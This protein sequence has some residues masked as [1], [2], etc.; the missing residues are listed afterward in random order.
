MQLKKY[1]VTT[2]CKPL[3]TPSCPHTAR[4]SPPP[5]GNRYPKFGD[6]HSHE[7][8]CIS[9]TY[10]NLYVTI[11]QHVYLP[12]ISFFCNIVKL[13][14]GDTFRDTAGA[15]HHLGPCL[16]SATVTEGSSMP[17]QITS[18]DHLPTQAQGFSISFLPQQSR[19]ARAPSLEVR[20]N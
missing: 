15:C 10:E 14:Q 11:S 19:H 18:R 3:H 12:A 13:I 8:I 6:G 4:P 7:H 9:I 5:P 20:R 2:G 17:A 1:N 16:I